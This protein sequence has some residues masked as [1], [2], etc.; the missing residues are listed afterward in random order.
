MVCAA[1]VASAQDYDRNFFLKRKMLSESTLEAQKS[2]NHQDLVQYYDGFGRPTVDIVKS[3]GLRSCDDIVTITEYSS[4]NRIDKVYLPGIK[5]Q[6]LN[7]TYVNDASTLMFDIYKKDSRYYTENIYENSPYELVVSQ[8]GPGENW[9][10]AGKAKCTEWHVN[11]GTEELL[12]RRYNLCADD[13]SISSSGLYPSGSLTAVKGT[14]EDGNVTIEFTNGLG[15]KVLFRKRC[16]DVNFDTYFVYDDWGNLRYVL[17]P[18][19]AD[20]LTAQNVSYNTATPAIRDYAYYYQ[21]DRRGNC[22]L[23]KL[24]GCEPIFMVYDKTNR[25]ILSQDGNQRVGKKWTVNKY[26]ILGRLLYTSEVIDGT[27]DGMVNGFKDWLVIEYFIGSNETYSQEDTGYSKYFYYIAP[28]K[29]LTVNYYD[30]YDFLDLPAA[31]TYKSKLSYEERQGY[32]KKYNNAKGLLT[33]TRTYLLDGSGKYTIAAMYYDNKGRVVQSHATNNLG[34]FEDDYFHYTFTGK[35]INHRHDHSAA[36]NTPTTEIYGYTYDHAERLLTVTHKLD[37]NTAISIV[38]NEYDE[39]GRLK[40]KTIPVETTT[41]SYNIRG[42]LTQA[43]GN[44]FKETLTYNEVVN[45]VSPST[46]SYSGNIS[47]MKWQAGNEPTERGYQFSYDGKGLLEKAL[48]GEG[49]NVALNSKYN[50]I[51][52]YDKMGNVKT[53]SRHGKYNGGFGTIDSLTYVYSGNQLT[54]VT[55]AVN[56]PMP[57][58]SFHFA[59]NANVGTEYV[60]DANGNMVQDFNKRIS[61]IEY[62]LLNLPSKLQFSEGHLA[63]YGYDASGKK[64]N[65]TY[66]TSKTNLMVP[67]GSIVP[68]QATNVAMTLRMDYCGNMIYEN[69]N[70][71]TILIEGGYITFNGTAPVYH[72]Y[73][74]DHLGDNRVVVN[75]NGTVEQVNHYYPFG[76]LFGENIGDDKQPYK[77][78]GKELDRMHGLDWYDYGARHYDAALGR[79]MCVDPLT[80]KYYDV[81]PYAYIENNPV[82]AIE[83][84]GRDNYK[85]NR[86]GSME[87]ICKT[88]DNFHSIYPVDRDGNM[89]MDAH[90]TVSKDFLDNAL[91]ISIKGK[92]SEEFGGEI[93]IYRTKIYSTMNRKEAVAFFEFAANNTDV[94][95]SHIETDKYSAV[96]TSFSGGDDA[97]NPYML[98]TAKINNISVLRDD[99]SHD[100]GNNMPSTGDI[101]LATKYPNIKFYIYDGTKYI[102]FDKTSNP[103]PEVIIVGHKGQQLKKY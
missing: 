70:L 31:S 11:S 54:K 96:G 90:F 15:Q 34:G 73:L 52:T 56:P 45:G 71:K 8:L 33:G 49:K 64:L 32:S 44:K 39:I 43:T 94:E 66:S 102:P 93:S 47:A 2:S 75:A 13:M 40:S 59:D 83:L 24:P 95:W 51:I 37:G 9:A 16:L 86:D 57:Y 103:W 50:E 4:M 100:Y 1:I 29:L 19:A 36:G 21:Y 58:G 79:W 60:Y 82:N 99:H 81:S 14:D 74:Q 55:D 63:E 76:G 48:Y 25:L 6:T 97:S 26:D 27:L 35:V 80:E 88:K 18:A 72:Y 42:W 30:N 41:Y 98:Y 17:P 23:K 46:P 84:D 85:L 91:P 53:L 78:N 67:M 28:T 101:K 61:K 62:N 22:I 68:P 87:L 77:Y 12:V 20:L 89:N 92:A 7:G 10:K 69:G 3:G 65:V 38:Q 5:S